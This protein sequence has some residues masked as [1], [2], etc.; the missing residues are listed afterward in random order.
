MDAVV[1]LD[2]V[3]EMLRFFFKN[4]ARSNTTTSLPPTTLSLTA[5]CVSSFQSYSSCNSQSNPTALSCTTSWR[6]LFQG[7]LLAMPLHQY[8]KEAA[9]SCSDSTAGCEATNVLP[10]L[11]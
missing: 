7:L 6:N 8:L 11:E 5:F 9:A 1:I 10:G 4:A 3:F 2:F